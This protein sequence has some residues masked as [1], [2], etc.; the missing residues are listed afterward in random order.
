VNWPTKSCISSRWHHEG[1][2]GLRRRTRSR[3]G[4]LL[5]FSSSGIPVGFLGIPNLLG[6]GQAA[7]E[8]VEPVKSA[9]DA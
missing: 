4:S 1:Q 2:L 9:D 7:G 6:D 8:F 3:R 5:V